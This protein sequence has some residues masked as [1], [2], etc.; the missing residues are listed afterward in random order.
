[1]T[2]YN[3]GNS[4][5]IINVLNL[6]IKRIRNS[7]QRRFAMREARRKME[8]HREATRRQHAER[9]STQKDDGKTISTA[10]PEIGLAES[11][12]YWLSIPSVSDGP[13]FNG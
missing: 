13:A 1:M 4:L 5:K 2:G 6:T 10:E 7:V 8:A 3:L 9:R 11:E 12:L